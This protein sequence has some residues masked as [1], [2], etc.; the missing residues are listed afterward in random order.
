M[1]N[2]VYTTKAELDYIYVDLPH[3]INQAQCS[4]VRVFDGASGT[5]AQGFDSGGWRPQIA[6]SEWNERA[7]FVGPR[8]MTSR[9]EL[10]IKVFDDPDQQ[11]QAMNEVR[12]MY[13]LSEKSST[14]VFIF[15][16]FVEN[17]VS[18]ILPT[19]QF[20]RGHRFLYMINLKSPVGKVQSELYHWPS[21][22]H[23]WKHR[24]RWWLLTFLKY[25]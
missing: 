23:R 19:W 21:V 2:Y 4:E 11:L 12:I 22:I 25:S 13:G 15:A 7:K 10:K 8:I 14:F 24:G 3:F 16:K 6:M 1:T 18:S 5:R 9:R 17:L 20:N